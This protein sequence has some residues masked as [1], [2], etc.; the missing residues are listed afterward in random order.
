VWAQVCQN[1]FPAINVKAVKLA[2]C[3]RV[4]L[5]DYDADSQVMIWMSDGRE[6]A[7]GPDSA[8]IKCI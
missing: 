5:L 2:A 8:C 3:K 7:R 4:V 6:G 1:M